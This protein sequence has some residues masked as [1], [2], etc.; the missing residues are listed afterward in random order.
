MATV[1]LCI[2]QHVAALAFRFRRRRPVSAEAAAGGRHLRSLARDDGAIV[3]LVSLLLALVLGTLVGSSYA[4]YAT[5]NSE[6]ETSPPVRFIR[7]SAR[8]IWAETRRARK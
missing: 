5:R 3:G 6:F 2:G 4:F 7:L 1:S 8:R